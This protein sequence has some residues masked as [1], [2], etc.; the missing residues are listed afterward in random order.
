MRRFEEIAMILEDVGAV[1]RESVPDL[2][3]VGKDKGKGRGLPQ[4]NRC[5]VVFPAKNLSK[6][7]RQQRQC[8]SLLIFGK[9]FWWSSDE[10]DRKLK[11]KFEEYTR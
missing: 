4:Y 1:N 8:P 6:Y 11:K 10:G 7:K 5:P 9:P 2:L 3:T